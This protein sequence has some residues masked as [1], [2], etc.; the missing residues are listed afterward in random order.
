MCRILYDPPCFAYC[1]GPDHNPLHATDDSGQ[2]GECRAK[3]LISIRVAPVLL[4]HS[5]NSL[6]NNDSGYPETDLVRSDRP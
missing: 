3:A 5:W 1:P 4:V 2:G 6:G